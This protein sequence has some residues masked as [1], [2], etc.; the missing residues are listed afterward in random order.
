MISGNKLLSFLDEHKRNEYDL[1]QYVFNGLPVYTSWNVP[2]SYAEVQFSNLIGSYTC[3]IKE[4]EERVEFLRNCEDRPCEEEPSITELEME[5]SSLADTI[6][7]LG[8][9]GELKRR[10]ENGEWLEMIEIAEFFGTS[11]QQLKHLINDCCFESRDIVRFV[12]MDDEEYNKKQALT[13]CDKP[14][15]SASHKKIMSRIYALD[16]RTN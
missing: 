4:Q 15:G 1:V 16:N 14:N 12:D 7:R 2:I 3:N 9:L 8:R 13:Q 11:R 6:R 5:E 10:F